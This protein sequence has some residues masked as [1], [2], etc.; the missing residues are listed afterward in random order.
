MAYYYAGKFLWNS[1]DYLKK[2]FGAKL[3][4]TSKTVNRFG[5]P[6]MLISPFFYG[7]RNI[8]PIALEV[9]NVNVVPFT[10]Y[11]LIG[12]AAWAWAFAEAGRMVAKVF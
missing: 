3:E 6:F 2:T 9:Y 1:W 8:I 7:I 4:A 11:N 10:I 5:S 12:T